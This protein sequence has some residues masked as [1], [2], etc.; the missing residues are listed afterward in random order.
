M[1]TNNS[2]LD[3]TAPNAGSIIVATDTAASLRATRRH[4]NDAVLG[5]AEP[6]PLALAGDEVAAK[7]SKRRRFIKGGA[8][9]VP[10]ALTLTSQ[11][12][13]AWHCNSTSAWGSGQLQNNT[14]SV[15]ARNELNRSGDEC[16]FINQWKTNNGSP[17]ARPELGLAVAK[18]SAVTKA[19]PATK[20]HPA[21]ADNTAV[22]DASVGWTWTDTKT[23]VAGSQNGSFNKGKTLLLRDL[24]V[25]TNGRL[26]GAASVWDMINGTDKFAA[27]IA[28]ALLN[29]KC[30]PNTVGAC[31]MR[32]DTQV[33]AL[34]KMATGQFTPTKGVTWGEAEIVQYLYDNWMAR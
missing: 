19:T 20:G 33:S 21:V 15:A 9:A 1:T 34:A 10:V 26:T 18:P 7:F 31:L 30:F 22:F 14:G 27:A 6:L 2:D 4:T 13:M 3:Q 28:T 11:P 29:E 24:G 25:R 8:A 12:V 32:G 17:W 16:F 23:K 5:T